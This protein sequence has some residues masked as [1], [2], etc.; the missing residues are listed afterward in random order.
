MLRG[1][2]VGR[3]LMPCTPVALNF[4]C[5]EVGKIGTSLYWNFLNLKNNLACTR[6]TSL[7]ASC[8]HA[9]TTA[10]ESMNFFFLRQISYQSQFHCSFVTM[11]LAW[12]FVAQWTCL[13]LCTCWP[14]TQIC[15][16]DVYT[17]TTNTS[18]LYWVQTDAH[19]AVRIA[20]TR[21]F[22]ALKNQKCFLK[23]SFS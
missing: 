5:N 13:P 15:T 6:N 9:F 12:H 3:L 22:W 16:V 4:N 7:L 18:V 17:L 1:G 21:S 23:S 14:P 11:E 2:D 8:K 19:I 20:F 10:L